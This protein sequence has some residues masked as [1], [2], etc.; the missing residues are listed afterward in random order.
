MSYLIA[1]I[2]AAIIA[3]TTPHVVAHGSSHPPEPPPPAQKRVAGSCFWQVPGYLKIINL[4]AATEIYVADKE[5]FVYYG[6]EYTR[7][8]TGS[9]EAN[10]NSIQQRIAECEKGN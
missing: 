1:G 7:V 4:Y 2:S 10:F 6:R 5:L 3:A 8:K 9:A